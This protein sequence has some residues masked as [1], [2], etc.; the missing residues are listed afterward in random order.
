MDYRFR[1]N[2]SE[3]RRVEHA[4]LGDGLAARFVVGLRAEFQAAGKFARRG[5]VAPILLPRILLAPENVTDD[6]TFGRIDGR[7]PPQ[8]ERRVHDYGGMVQI[9]CI[10]WRRSEVDQFPINT[11]RHGPREI[12][13]RGKPPGRA[14]ISGALVWPVL[15]AA[16]GDAGQGN[17]GLQERRAERGV[18]GPTDGT[19][20]RY[21][22]GQR[23]FE[24]NHVFAIHHAE[25]ARKVLLHQRQTR[26]QGE[27]AGSLFLSR[28]LNFAILHLRSPVSGQTRGALLRRRA[29]ESVDTDKMTE[30]S[31]TRAVRLPQLAGH[32][33]RI[34]QWAELFRIV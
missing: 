2:P 17:T 14:G 32:T 30:R 22:A 7:D 11:W 4:V 8:H 16:S 23:A 33:D 24:I 18:L 13:T 15:R 9:M 6:Q 27:R 3:C 1:G 5:I 20:E 19:V 21:F 26:R 29:A 28:L 34:P 12:H 31:G 10:V 25:R